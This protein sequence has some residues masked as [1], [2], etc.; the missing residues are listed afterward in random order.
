MGFFDAALFRLTG[1]WSGACLFA[2]L[3]FAPPSAF[4]ADETGTSASLSGFA[5]PDYRKRDNRLQFILYGDKATNL[6]AFIDLV[7]PKL[8]FIHEH[9][10]NINDITPLGDVKPYPLDSSPEEIRKFW[11]DKKHCRALIMSTTAQYDKNSKV[12]RGDTP[13]YFRSREIDIDGV[14]FDADYDKKLIHIRSKVRMVIRPE[15]RQR[16][17]NASMQTTTKTTK[18]QPK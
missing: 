7:N 18:D 9:V 15:V 16:E 6:G 4:S 13:A 2:L 11:S 10:T 12:L 5:L 14:G 3:A 1:L 17:Q 8:D